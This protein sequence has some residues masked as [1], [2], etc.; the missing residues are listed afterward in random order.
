M[1]NETKPDPHI[2]PVGS[3][4]T[5][6]PGNPFAN[7]AK[8]RQSQDYQEFLGGEAV[9]KLNVRTLKEDMHLRVNPDPNYSL[10]VSTL[11]PLKRGGAPTSCSRNFAMPL[12][13]CR[14]VAICISRL[15]ATANISCC[16]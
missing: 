13:R 16:R 15:M 10:P 11:S 4:Q 1:T 6:T 7:L 8:L 5:I 14:V 3:E 2:K 12:G 9:T